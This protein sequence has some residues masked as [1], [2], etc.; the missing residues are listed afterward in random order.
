MG[1]REEPAQRVPL[2]QRMRLDIA[3]QTRISVTSAAW[4]AAKRPENSSRVSPGRRDEM[5]IALTMSGVVAPSST[6][7]SV[8]TTLARR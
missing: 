2:E 8:P 5:K 4:V 7:V 6:T 3:T 1:R